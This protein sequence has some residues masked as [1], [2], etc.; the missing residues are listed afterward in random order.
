MDDRLEAAIVEVAELNWGRDGTC[1]RTSQPGALSRRT[2][3]NYLN[4]ALP[5]F[6]KNT[7]TQ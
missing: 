2:T 5:K 7:V 1:H 4:R 6:N 3:L